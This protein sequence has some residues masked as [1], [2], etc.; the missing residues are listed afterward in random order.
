MNLLFEHWRFHHSPICSFIH[1]GNPFGF[2]CALFRALW[3][4]ELNRPAM[5]LKSQLSSKSKQKEVVCNE[6][7]YEI[8]LCIA[9]KLYLGLKRYFKLGSEKACILHRRNLSC[10]LSNLIRILLKVSANNKLQHASTVLALERP[11]GKYQAGIN[12]N[13]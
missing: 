7:L 6:F 11:P 10:M 1:V 12:R 3:V 2:L 5:L 13:I 9:Y 4:V 8:C